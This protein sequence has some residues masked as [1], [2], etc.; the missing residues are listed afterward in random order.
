[1]SLCILPLILQSFVKETYS[2]EQVLERLKSKMARNLSV[3]ATFLSRLF[4]TFGAYRAHDHH[5][6]QYCPQTYLAA[7]LT[8]KDKYFTVYPPVEEEDTLHQFVSLG[9]SALRVSGVEDAAEIV[10]KAAETT[11]KAAM[12]VAKFTSRFGSKAVSN[13]ART[14]RGK[15]DMHMGKD[16]IAKLQKERYRRLGWQELTWRDLFAIVQELEAWQ[17]GSARFDNPSQGVL[18]AE[19]HEDYGVHERFTGLLV[20]FFPTHDYEEMQFFRKQWAD[21]KL[22]LKIRMRARNNEGKYTEGAHYNPYASTNSWAGE[23]LKPWQCTLWYQP[24]DEIR[25]YFGDETALYFAWLGIYTKSLG[26]QSVFG[27]VTMLLGTVQNQ[28]DIDPDLNDFTMFYSVSVAVWSVMFLQ[29]WHRRENELRFLWGTEGLADNQTPRM[30]FKGKLDVNKVTGRETIIE[31]GWVRGLARKVFSWTVVMTLMACT[32]TSALLAESLNTKKDAW[33]YKFDTNDD[34]YLDVVELKELFTALNQRQDMTVISDVQA[35]ALLANWFNGTQWDRRSNAMGWDER[36]VPIGPYIEIDGAAQSYPVCDVIKGQCLGRSVCGN[37]VQNGDCRTVFNASRGIPVHAGCE[38]SRD[39]DH[40][41][42]PAGKYAVFRSTEPAHLEP[43]EPHSVTGEIEDGRCGCVNFNAVWKRTP[44]REMKV[45]F[46]T[47]QE[48]ASE[49]LWTGIGGMTNLVLLQTFGTIFRRLADTLNY[50]ENHRL[51]EIHNRALILKIFLFEFVNN[52]FV[53]FYIAYLRHI[54]FPVGVPQKCDKSCLGELQTKLFIVFTGKTL[55][56]KVPEY[57]VPAVKKWLALKGTDATDDEM[58]L[59]KKGGNFKMTVEEQA[60]L[61]PCEGMFDDFSQMVTQFGYLALF[62][63]ACSLAPLLAF[64]NNVTEIRTDAWSVCN[65]SQRPTW[66]PVD[67]IG[68]WATVLKALAMVAVIVNSTMVFF[69]GSQMACPMDKDKVIDWYNETDGCMYGFLGCS[70]RPDLER[71]TFAERRLGGFLCSFG[72]SGWTTPASSKTDCPVTDRAILEKQG[73]LWINPYWD[74]VQQWYMGDRFELDGIDYRVTVSRLWIWAVC[75]EHVVLILRFALSAMA[76]TEPLWVETAKDTLGYKVEKMKHDD[77]NS[78]VDREELLKRRAGRKGAKEAF[79]KADLDGNG[80][81]DMSELEHLVVTLGMKPDKEDIANIWR[82]LDQDQDGQVSFEEFDIWWSINGG[83]NKFQLRNAIEIFK[84]LDTDGSGTLDKEE[85][86]QLCVHLGM[87][88]LTDKQATKL[89][90]EID[91]DGDGDVTIEE[92]DIWWQENGGAKFKS[93]PKPAPGDMSRL[94]KFHEKK[95]LQYTVERKMARVT[96]RD[97]GVLSS[98][99]TPRRSD[100]D[101]EDSTSM[102]GDGTSSANARRG[103]AKAGQLVL[104]ACRLPGF[105]VLLFLFLRR[106]RQDGHGRALRLRDCRV[107][108]LTCSRVCVCVCVRARVCVCACSI[109]GLC[110]LWWRCR[111]ADERISR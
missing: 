64:A 27:V 36:T 108:A 5:F 93:A 81:V 33:Y 91:V 24:I 51:E 32:V 109:H 18:S 3:T 34:K 57:I 21:L 29:Q 86:K 54:E 104:R 31:K 56:K 49:N 69:V 105:F 62:A 37:W 41:Y 22:V 50:F 74:T 7:E 10:G 83:K 2:S 77:P 76:P 61:T 110:G 88:A 15:K 30:E 99:S 40:S 101:V 63:P 107:C 43:C 71:P 78:I 8:E 95:Q 87:K 82:D 97:N 58:E 4:T 47:L 46:R 106:I 26:M 6:K 44:Y 23:K 73:S 42:Q 39:K 14:A 80:Y 102:P 17:S 65:L 90:N 70:P 45:P 103:A 60:K 72:G 19:I 66:K 38:Q 96:S 111:R 9:D 79:E 68:A 1:M 59:K 100:F 35:D 89:M 67:S 12:R 92:F 84:Q 16:E 11:T 48:A 52:Y 94:Q 20:D 25:D 55:F 53:M 75:M 85:L 13:A 98:P 28:G